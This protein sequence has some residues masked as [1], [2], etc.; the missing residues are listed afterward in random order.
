MVPLGTELESHAKF[1][2]WLAKALE[3]NEG[4]AIP[5]FR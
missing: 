3:P 2:S 5:S 1:P 4:P